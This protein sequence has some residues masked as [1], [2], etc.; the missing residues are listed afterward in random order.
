MANPI[1][2]DISHY[3]P[4]PDWNRVLAGGTAG[5]IL[6]CTEGA[7]YTDP[8]FYGRQIGARDAGLYVASY[9]FL[10]PG[11]MEGQMRRYRDVLAPEPG[12]RMVIDYEDA[13][14]PFSDLEKAALWLMQETAC[15]VAVY[16]SNVL[17]EA[18]AGRKSEVLSMTSLWQ[19]RYSTEPPDVPT[20]IWPT[21]SL[22]QYTD[23]AKVDGINGHV[24]GNRWN[25]DP[26][27]LQDWFYRPAAVP[28]PEGSELSIDLITGPVP[29][30]VRLVISVNGRRVG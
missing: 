2:I 17:V 23:Q 24:D 4:T 16:G 10:R 21:W 6:K 9:H 3:Q 28:E 1:V 11:D 14:I 12:D 22:W 19:A 27:R 5:V 15:E 30:G 7:S 8:T 26:A 18:C 13:D 29:P 25:G 20:G